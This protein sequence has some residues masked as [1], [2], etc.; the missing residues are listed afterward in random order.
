M[1]YQKNKKKL[2]I[3]EELT[4]ISG[5]HMMCFIMTKKWSLFYDVFHF[6]C[7][8]CKHNL[9]SDEC[10]M[11]LDNKIYGSNKSSHNSTTKKGNIDELY[12][13]VVLYV[14]GVTEDKSN[15]KKDNDR[16]NIYYK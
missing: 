3:D 11:N 5:K 6:G 2:S 10:V 8:N 7:C 14:R 16:F 1:L 4:V 9:D 13:D 12:S 15:M